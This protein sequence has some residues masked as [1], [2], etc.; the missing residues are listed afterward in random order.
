MAPKAVI[1]LGGNALGSDPVK[2]LDKIQ[3]ASVHIV[4]LIAQGYQVILTHGN[5]PQVGTIN[6]AFSESSKF[7]DKIPKMKLPECAAMSQGYIGY[8]LET[9]I[10]NEIAKRSLPQ[11]VVTVVTRMEVDPNDPAFS[12]PVKPIGS[13]YTKEEVEQI[14][15][16]EPSFTYMEDAGRGYRRT[17][18]SPYPISIPEPSPIISLLNNNYI[19]VACGGGGIPVVKV[20]NGIYKGVD[21][22][23]D[24]DLATSKLADLVNADYM[25]ILTCVDS[26]YINWNQPNQAAIKKMSVTQAQKYCQEGQFAPGSMLPKVQAAIEF[27]RNN[28]QRTAIICS[29]EHASL[30][31]KAQSGTQIC[32][33]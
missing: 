26:V 15:K 31:I 4:D 17:V 24:K 32:S 21:A 3:L 13:H 29:L 27:V 23:I 2:Q 33:E 16:K 22:V 30:A 9:A 25:L 18:P 8:H 19:V 6:L 10:Q 20:E 14:A 5:G 12:H 11:K 7:N 28:P 1:A